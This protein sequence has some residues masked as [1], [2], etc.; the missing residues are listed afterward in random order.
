[1]YKINLIIS[2]KTR[3][4]TLALQI[5]WVTLSKIIKLSQS[6][7]FKLELR[8]MSNEIIYWKEDYRH[9]IKL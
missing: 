5:G 6:K 8:G 1:M 3:D 9:I 4:L 2:Q 7:L